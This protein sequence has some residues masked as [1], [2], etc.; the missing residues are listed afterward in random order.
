VDAGR[1]RPR[2]A[3]GRGALGA[4]LG[5]RRRPGSRRRLG[6]GGGLGRDSA[7]LTAGE[8]RSGGAWPVFEERRFDAY[9][10]TTSAYRRAVDPG[11][12][13]SA[14]TTRPLR[15]A[16]DARRGAVRPE[17]FAEAPNAPVV[18]EAAP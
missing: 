11:V 18:V 9:A 14:S 15:A 6:P 17:V 12:Q 10:R 8:R 7:L 4:H 2:A 5:G 1:R 3:R 16:G 13:A